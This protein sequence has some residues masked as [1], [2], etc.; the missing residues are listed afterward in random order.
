MSQTYSVRINREN[1]Y[2]E[3][4]NQKEYIDKECDNQIIISKSLIDVFLKILN[5]DT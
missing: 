4:Y 3:N 1:L 2:K 5:N